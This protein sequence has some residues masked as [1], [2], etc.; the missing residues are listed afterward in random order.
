M[1]QNEFLRFGNKIRRMEKKTFV[2]I[3]EENP[4]TDQSSGLQ[5]FNFL[6]NRIDEKEILGKVKNGRNRVQRL[7]DEL[8]VK[9][10]EIFL[11]FVPNLDQ[12]S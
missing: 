5:N 12:S 2:K 11:V 6:V 4:V 3:L 7:W 9:V 1:A 8:V 10:G